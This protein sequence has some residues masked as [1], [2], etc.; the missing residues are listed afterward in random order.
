MNVAFTGRGASLRRPHGQDSPVRRHGDRIAEIILSLISR[1]GSARKRAS[2][3]PGST[4][5]IEHA[6]LPGLDEGQRVGVVLERAHRQNVSRP[7]KG[8]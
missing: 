2:D 7:S 3:L 5:P 6:D 4:G 8:D 1:K